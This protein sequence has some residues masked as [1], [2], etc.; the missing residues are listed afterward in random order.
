MPYRFLSKGNIL[1]VLFALFA[2]VWS[3][4]YA[5]AEETEES[6]S[7]MIDLNE[8]PGA[9]LKV[10]E[11]GIEVQITGQDKVPPKYYSEEEIF[12]KNWLSLSK[13]GKVFAQTRVFTETC[14]ISRCTLEGNVFYAVDSSDGNMRFGGSTIAYLSPSGVSIQVFNG[15]GMGLK[16]MGIED[17]K[18]LFS[19]FEN[20]TVYNKKLGNNTLLSR[21][22]QE[23]AGVSENWTDMRAVKAV[24]TGQKTPHDNFWVYRFKLL[25]ENNEES[26][27][28][29]ELLAFHWSW[30]DSYKGQPLLL[31]MG[32]LEYESGGFDVTGPFLHDAI[33]LK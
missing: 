12:A 29:L 23:D 18:I 26:G 8:N 13:N 21:P 2:F 25:N 6:E 15:S 19:G 7:I 1:A 11:L 31:T 10:E 22:E 32:Q 24:Y 27:E 33:P 20:D 4:P 30:L 14:W 16:S 5:L 28:E 3:V 9:V 17:G